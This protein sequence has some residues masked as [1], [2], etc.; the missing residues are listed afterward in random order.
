[1]KKI[2]IVRYC[3]IGFF[4]LGFSALMIYTIISY[5]TKEVRSILN[6]DKKEMK[7]TNEAAFK[8]YLS[9][10]N[11]IWYYVDGK[12]NIIISIGDNVDRSRERNGVIVKSIGCVFLC[13]AI[14][15]TIHCVVK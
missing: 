15:T 2:D 5:F 6:G 10:N 11:K 1:M 14:V 3:L 8:D 12:D 4:V 7:F 13:A 9:G